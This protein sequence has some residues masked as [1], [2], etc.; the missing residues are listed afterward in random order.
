MKYS[1]INK[2]SYIKGRDFKE[3]LISIL[4]NIKIDDLSLDLEKDGVFPR[5]YE[6]LFKNINKESPK[7]I[8]LQK[9]RVNTIL[10]KHL[11][12]KNI[13][14]IIK[15]INEIGLDIE[16]FTRANCFRERLVLNGTSP[17]FTTNY[18]FV[19]LER[20]SYIIVNLTEKVK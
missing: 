11:I 10:P 3:I 16:W 6:T 7:D 4:E 14:N 5:L 18:T 13:P 17:N 19:P 2:K 15:T 12:V 8:K 20:M 9:Y 1:K